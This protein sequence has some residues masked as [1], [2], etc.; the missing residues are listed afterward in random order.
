MSPHR[1]EKARRER[2]AAR[3]EREA[4]RQQAGVQGGKVDVGRGRTR[5]RGRR[6]PDTPARA[7]RRRRRRVLLL[8][9]IVWF[10]LL[11]VGC[12]TAVT[13]LFTW[14]GSDE[15]AD[16]EHSEAVESFEL[17]GEGGV[18]ERWK[19]AFN[20]GTAH[21]AESAEV[22]YGWWRA[23]D[24]LDRALEQAPEEHRCTVQLNRAW[25]WE[26]LG[27]QDMERSAERA[28]WAVEAAEILAAGEEYPDDAPWYDATPEELEEDARQSAE[29]AEWAYGEALEAR[30]DPACASLSA[31][32]Q[33]EN[34]ESQAELEDKQ[35]QAEAAAAPEEQ[36][37]PE[38]E[39]Q[40]EAERQQ[41]LEE[42]NAEA[43]AQTEAE[44]QQEAAE[45]SGTL[46]GTGG[47]GDE[48][49]GGGPPAG[50]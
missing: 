20:L 29:N 23:L 16:G 15:Y 21:A 31:P 2:E 14:V 28:G 25:V 18:V 5:R 10:P 26:H 43:A 41:A 44:R 24:L 49:G 34:E 37:A 40:T 27:D 30:Q 7:S 1:R 6:T 32:E 46:D 47:D 50:W 39:P 19:G 12:D 8:T 11:V 42:R 22:G 4:A 48:E 33:Q 38:P 9:A 17:A 13:P 35:E 36:P 45:E 3:R